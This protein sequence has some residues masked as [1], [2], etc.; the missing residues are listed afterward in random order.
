M[1]IIK[2]DTTKGIKGFANVLLSAIEKGISSRKIK[3]EAEKAAIIQI[4][5]AVKANQDLFRPDRGSDGGDDLIGL[6]GIGQGGK[7]LTDKIR[8]AWKFLE[9]IRG[10]NLSSTF[11]KRVKGKF[12]IINYEIDLDRFYNAFDS[13][14]I[15]RARKQQ[16]IPISWMSNL[17]QGIPTEQVREYPAEAK[18]FVFVS[19]GE[20]FSPKRS[21]TGLGHMV[22]SSKIKIPATQFSFNGRGRANTFGKLFIA[23][24]KRLKSSAFRKDLE[25]RIANIINSGG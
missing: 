16:D 3:V 9:P 1:T 22:S 7:P 5:K 20:N 11:R 25:S 4:E 14:Y 15:S 18:P 21:R 24:E 13:T 2:V 12:G 6:L 10:K 17:I 19:S 8:N 23:I